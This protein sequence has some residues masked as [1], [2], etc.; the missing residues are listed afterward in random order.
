MEKKSD[1]I[2]PVDFDPGPGTYNLAAPS[3][4]SGLTDVFISR[5][6]RAGNFSWATQL[7]G[8]T[9]YALAVDKAGLVYA[10]GDD[11]NISTTIY[12]LD[13]GGNLLWAKQI[14][15]SICWALAVNGNDELFMT[16]QFEGTKDFDPGPGIYN[17]TATGSGCFISKLGSGGNL[18]WA[19]QLS[20]TN[21]VRARALAVDGQDQLY[22][23][24]FFE[25]TADFDPG[26]AT[27][28]LTIKGNTGWDVFIHKLKPD[29][30]AL[31]LVEGRKF[32]AFPNPT[33]GGLVVV[34][35]PGLQPSELIVR[36]LLGQ[37][38]ER[39]LTRNQDHTELDIKGLRGVYL[40][41]IRNAKGQKESVR[42]LKH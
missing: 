42:I 31:E 23:T 28:N 34:F 10:S 30:L 24:G 8:G 22:T 14:G 15:A 26:P 29:N 32:R 36:N 17:L 39:K 12:K 13:A 40:L 5:L 27:H 21:H 11:I 16:G 37:A 35:E 33:A 3:Y 9:G 7:P 41:E 18:M 38:V 1:Y 25:A 20:G 4:L 19:V 2:W 6:D